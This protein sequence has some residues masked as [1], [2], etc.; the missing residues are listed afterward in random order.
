MFILKTQP[1][2]PVV[3]FIKNVSPPSSFTSIEFIFL[4]CVKRNDHR[5]QIIRKIVKVMIDNVREAYRVEY[6]NI[7]AIEKTYFL[8]II[9]LN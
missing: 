1:S 9:R 5:L 2:I 3:S 6:I 7:K 4:W 8:L